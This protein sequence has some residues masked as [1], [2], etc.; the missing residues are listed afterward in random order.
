MSWKIT[1]KLAYNI[2]QFLVNLAITI[3][4]ITLYVIYFNT[5]SEVVLIFAVFQTQIDPR[6]RSIAIIKGTITALLPYIAINPPKS[7]VPR[8]KIQ[9]TKDIVHK[10]INTIIIFRTKSASTRAEMR[11]L[12]L[13][14]I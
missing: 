11:V 5:K 14:M 6:R 13:V 1:R 8:I 2:T 10:V 9:I 7:I 4:F 3:F 12:L